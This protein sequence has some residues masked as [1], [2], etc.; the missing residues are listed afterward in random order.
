MNRIEEAWQLRRSNPT[1]SRQYIEES[2][3][4][5]VEEMDDLLM[6]HCYTV[7]GILN[8]YSNKYD[9]ALSFLRKAEKF[10]YSYPNPLFYARNMNTQGM[11]HIILGD[12]TNAISVLHKGLDVSREHKIDEMTIFML[13][14]IAEIY[15]DTNNFDKSILNLQEAIALNIKQ[16]HVLTGAI[17]S[18]LALCYK[19]IGNEELA[20]VYVNT[21]IE[22]AEAMGD[23]HTLGLCYIVISLIYLDQEDYVNAKEYIFKS[24]A[25]REKTNDE[26]AIANSY[27]VLAQIHMKEEHYHKVIDL[28]EKALG[29]VINIHSDAILTELYTLLG[30][31]HAKLGAYEKSVFY[32]NKLE[33]EQKKL[34]NANL[35]KSL[36]VL[37]A[38]QKIE[39][40]R[41]DAEIYRLSNIEL[42]RKSNELSLIS[43][44]GQSL[45][46]ALDFDIVIHQIYESLKE[47][48]DVPIMA[49]GLIDSDNNLNYRI[50]LRY[51]EKLP[52]YI[53][54]QTDNSLGLQA[55]KNNKTV[56]IDD[57]N[58]K[59]EKIVRLDNLD[60]D[61]V[62]SI[63]FCPLYV[64]KR[65]LG[66]LTLQSY[67]QKAYNKDS[68]RL[69][70]GLSSYIAIAIDNANK[71]S[72]ISNTAKELAETIK[73]LELT[74][75]DL[76][77]A[78]TLA[79][80]GRLVAGVAHELNTPIGSSITTISFAQNINSSTNKMFENNM[81]T[82]K[83]LH[84]YFVKNEEALKTIDKGIKQASDM[85]KSF[86]SLA[87]T[88]QSLTQKKLGSNDL[89]KLLIGNV[90]YLLS[91]HSVQL[92]V[93]KT[94]FEVT[95]Y[96][97]IIIEI[98]KQLISNSIHHSFIDIQNPR[99]SIEF[100]EYGDTMII[101][102]TDNGRKIDK[103]IQP[104]IFEPFFGT[105]KQDGFMG[106][107]LNAVHNMVSQIL[108]G[109]IEYHDGFIIKIKRK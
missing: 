15:K 99:I 32:Y 101:T 7:L 108:K 107:G 6:N 25:V 103:K 81:L 49:L 1:L 3:K 76:V 100:K 43:K 77:K 69:L 75:Q 79:G 18:S 11:A 28:S 89:R 50:I 38:E 36:S 2:M 71:A 12:Y 29:L 20:F 70:E 35:E 47:F 45:I 95:T 10:Y 23:Y 93:N 33:Y 54:K 16:D 88:E 41:K 22:H 74:Q 109:S 17:L 4:L 31:A 48:M 24:I 84:E 14:N 55:I 67:E 82:K 27:T 97:D 78:E 106:I 83:Q 94:E 53:V 56:Y 92:D 40:I 44:I 51:D 59:D 91:K 85:I 62:Q 34:F 96:P 87:V 58:H 5:A 64:D 63:L 52:S 46:N 68:I 39:S 9:S 37:T 86:K 60:E 72:I 105:K 26:F 65:A 73:M 30:Q 104:F 21:S 98:L 42:K 102:H 13:Y 8:V 80:M 19:K 61:P 66:V 90:S 57:F